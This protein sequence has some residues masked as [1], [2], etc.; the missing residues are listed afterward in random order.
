MR[1]SHCDGQYIACLED[2]LDPPLILFL[3]L[4]ADGALG[5]PRFL[6]QRVPHPVEL[7]GRLITLGEERLNHGSHRKLKGIL[8][9]VPLCLGMVAIGFVLQQVSLF[10]LVEVVVVAIMICQK[11][12]VQHAR[13][14][15]SG[16]RLSLAEGRAIVARIVG[17]DTSGLDRSDVVRAAVESVAE[18]FSDGIVAPAFW[19]LAG[20]LPGLLVYKLVNTADSMVGY[21]NERFGDFGWSFAR[22]D[23]LLN[24]I[25]A[26]LSAVLIK[27]WKQP[28]AD[29]K[30]ILA[31]AGKHRSPNAGW[32]EAA[33]ALVLGI[34]L[35][36]PRTYDGEAR[37]YPYINEP[38]RHQLTEVDLDNAILLIRKAWAGFSGLVLLAALLI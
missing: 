10:G 33:V 31:D 6:W 4:L 17:R 28:L 21:K 20:G 18:S 30:R 1:V 2:S 12:L 26:R 37:D 13:A 23:D 35:S 27:L 24:W 34:S 25:P 11:S 38:G 32:P 9:L 36:G 5:E 29:W 7:M 8:L 14:V 19:Y 16:L 3:A 22:L 15:A